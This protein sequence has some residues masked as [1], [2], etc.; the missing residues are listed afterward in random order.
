MEQSCEKERGDERL[1]YCLRVITLVKRGD[2]KSQ[3]RY[4]VIA[5]TWKRAYRHALQTARV[6]SFLST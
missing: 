4:D 6:V 1:G 5:G 3:D 2:L